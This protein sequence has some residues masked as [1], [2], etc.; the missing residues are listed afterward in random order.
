[1][2][3]LGVGAQVLIEYLF[4]MFETLGSTPSTAKKIFLLKKK[5]KKNYAENYYRHQNKSYDIIKQ[6][7]QIVMSTTEKD[8]DN[9]SVN[10]CSKLTQQSKL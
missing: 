9:L 3:V 6:N 2:C 4:N 7:R 10:T 5:K 1:M 8:P